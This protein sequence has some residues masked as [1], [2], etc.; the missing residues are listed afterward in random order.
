VFADLNLFFE[1]KNFR[2]LPWAYPDYSHIDF[3]GFFTWIR[4]ILKKK[5]D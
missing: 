3:I 4:E 2:P 1:D 5:L